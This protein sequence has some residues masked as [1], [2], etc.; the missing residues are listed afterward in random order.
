MPEWKTIRAPIG[1]AGATARLLYGADVRESLAALPESSVH[2]VVTSPPYWGL[3]NYGTPAT[4]WGGKAGCPHDWDE[5]RVY[6]DSPTRDGGEGVGF[7]DA[8][9]TK[10]QRW[11]TSNHCRTCGAWSGQLGLEPSP[12][13][14]VA[15]L[16]EVFREV[17]RVL[18]SDGVCWVNL[19]DSYAGTGSGLK[20]KDLALIPLRVVLALQADGWWVRSVMPWVKRNVMPESCTDR[21]T[22]AH[23]YWFMLAKSDTYFYDIDA[24]RKS[25]ESAYSQDAISKAGGAGGVRPEGNNFSKQ[26][27]H[28]SEEGTPR[29]RAERAALLNTAGRNRRTSDTWVESLDVVIEEQ[30]A[31]LA[32]LRAVRE[33][34]LVTSEDGMPIGIRTSTTPYKGSHFAVFPPQLIEPLILSTTSAHGCCPSCAAPWRRQVQEEEGASVADLTQRST[35]HYNT[36]DRY[37]AGN[38]GNSGLDALADK[39]RRGVGRVTRDWAPTCTCPDNDGSGR[40]VVLDPFSGSA[41]T[42]MVSLRLGRSYIG[43]D[44][45]ESYLPLAEARILQMDAPA[46]KVPEPSGSV[47]DLF[48]ED[49]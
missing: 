22:T 2:C 9:T 25:N 19:G 33:S 23:E 30:E 36:A 49:S 17:R 20:P 46:G 47:L 15:N 37:G 39:M 16:V 4:V 5:R 29:T 24:V 7:H 48:G 11:T 31:Y 28:A 18:R 8:E 35:A 44:L 32:H 43:L 3:R 1:D 26:A 42:G 13:M 27:R 40:A 45:N 38:G 12:D 6:K 41:T 21:P 34:G 14:F 10:S